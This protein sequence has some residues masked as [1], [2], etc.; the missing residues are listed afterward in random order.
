MAIGSGVD[1]QFGFKTESVWGTPVTVDRFLEFESESVKANVA[2]V[3]SKGLGQGRYLRTNRTKRYTKDAGGSITFPVMNKGMGLLFQH[4]L[5]AVSTAVDTPVAGANQHTFTGGSAGKAGLSATVQ[6]GKPDITGTVRPFTLAGGK[7]V[8]WELKCAL[9]EGLVAST[10][11]DFKSI[12]TATALAS[13]SFA[14]GAEQFIFTEGALTL[15]GGAKSVRSFSLKKTEPLKTDRRFIGNSKLEQLVN[16]MADISGQLECEFEDLDDYAAIV[17]GTQAALVLTFTTASF[18]TGTT[19]SVLTITVPK[20]EF[21]GDTP[22][23]GGPDVLM[24]PLPFRALYDG[25]NEP[26]TVLYQTAD[27]TP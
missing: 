22:V 13:K 16:G 14:S 19:P 24:Q 8:T 10:D 4:M 23:V 2:N 3:D 27:A 11:W 5:G 18:I 26:V 9:D 15:G 6:V 25:S 7:I 20:I 12:V 17:A 1:A 21:M